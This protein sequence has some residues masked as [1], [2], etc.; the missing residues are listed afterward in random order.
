MFTIS[1]GEDEARPIVLLRAD[2]ATF[3]DCA[4]DT[5]SNRDIVGD[6][7]TGESVNNQH[8]VNYQVVYSGRSCEISLANIVGSVAQSAKPNDNF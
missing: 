3:P 4:S 1:G 8:T 6:R 7:L 5:I 2:Q